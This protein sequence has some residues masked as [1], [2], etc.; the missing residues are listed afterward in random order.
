MDYVVVMKGRP[1]LVTPAK[2]VG[3]AEG[4]V[5]VQRGAMHA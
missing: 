3:C 5:I 4:E 2:E 1:V